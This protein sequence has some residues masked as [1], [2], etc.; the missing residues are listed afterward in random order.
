MVACAPAEAPE[1]QESPEAP[2]EV[3]EQETEEEAQEETAEES[4]DELREELE[5][6][7]KGSPEYMVEYDFTAEGYTG[8]MTMYMLDGKLRV[9]SKAQGVESRSFITDTVTT[10]TNSNGWTCFQIGE[11][12]ESY[13]PSEQINIEDS[14]KDAGFEVIDV[15]SRTIAGEEARCFTVRDEG[16]YTICYAQS[17]AML[18]MEYD[19][20][21]QF[22]SYEATSYSDSV[23]ASAFELPAE[24]QNFEDMVPDMGDFDMGGY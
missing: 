8:T 13:A 1:S 9:D 10:C 5:S 19:I 21:G 11:P 18:A 20:Q 12:E 15:S 4:S 14:M 22:L 17:G 16:E 3:Q 2:E 23:S 7:L 6:F 24:P